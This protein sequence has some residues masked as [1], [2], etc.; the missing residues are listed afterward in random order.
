M[1]TFDHVTCALALD[2]WSKYFRVTFIGKQET[3]VKRKS[4][5]KTKKKV[6]IHSKW[7]K[8]KQHVYFD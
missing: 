3:L 5:V 1:I 4:E 6:S 7:H 8:S 2:L